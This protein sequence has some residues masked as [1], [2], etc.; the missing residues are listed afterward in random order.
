M[1]IKRV[2]VLFDPVEY[3]KLKQVAEAKGRS[4]GDLVREAVRSKYLVPHETKRKQAVR[5][6]LSGSLELE[7][8]EWQ[9]LERVIEKE[10]TRCHVPD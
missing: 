4:V 6:L 9:E 8:P 10:V 1:A 3:Q 2:E 5:R 7:W